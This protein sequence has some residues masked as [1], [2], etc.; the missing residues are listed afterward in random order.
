[1]KGLQVLYMGETK[2]TEA[3]VKDLQATLPHCEIKR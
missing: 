1:V 2:V 3:G